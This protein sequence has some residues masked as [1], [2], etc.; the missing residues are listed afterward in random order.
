VKNSNATIMQ[1]PRELALPLADIGLDLRPERQI[2]PLHLEWVR[3]LV[4]ET[5]PAEWDAIQVRRWPGSDPY[6]DGEEARP[7]QVISGYHRVTAARALDLATIRAIVV[8]APT[9]ADFTLL[10]LKGNL[11][12]GVQMTT[13]EQRAAIRRLRTLGL[14]EGDIAKQ[15]G[16]PRGTIHNW[17]SNRITNAAR[18]VRTQQSGGDTAPP[19]DGLGLGLGLDATWRVPPTV[20]LDARR[21]QLVSSA[22]HD[23]LAGTP[24]G[25]IEPS[26]V[27]AWVETLAPDTRN[28]L[29]GDIRQ[30]V[31]WLSNLCK[32][33]DVA[34]VASVAKREREGDV[35]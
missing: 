23:F 29:T 30:T 22:V 3:R 35:A 31:A 12:H 20:R 18:S 6:P 7:W 5:D 2:R 21:I 17:L 10:A 8:E 9:E 28:S 27:L 4:E 1:T 32:V 34:S 15:T 14:S 13:E 26:D 33:L 16:I 11:Q 25:V 24:C 19:D